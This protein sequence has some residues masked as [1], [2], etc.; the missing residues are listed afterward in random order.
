MLQQFCREGLKSLTNQWLAHVREIH[1]S[2][3]HFFITSV[4][5]IWTRITLYHNLAL[6]MCTWSQLLTDFEGSI[7]G[8]Q[9]VKWLWEL[10]I[11][12]PVDYGPIWDGVCDAFQWKKQKNPA[13]RSAA[14]ARCTV[15]LNAISS[16]MNWSSQK[17]EKRGESRVRLIR[18]P[19][20]QTTVPNRAYGFSILD[21]GS[22][23]TFEFLKIEPLKLAI[24]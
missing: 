15:V 23:L 14:D 3:P 5:I 11:E 24:S 19:L 8:I 2:V 4:E 17:R 10:R 13:K 12:N 9:E 18:N 1:Y 7:L 22:H 6:Y 16:Q 20:P 21:Y